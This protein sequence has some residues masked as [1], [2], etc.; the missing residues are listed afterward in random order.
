MAETVAPETAIALPLDL[1]NPE[2]L[3]QAEPSL[4]I[5]RLDAAE[6]PEAYGLDADSLGQVTSVNQLRDIQP[7]DWAYQA[8]QSLVERYGCL[9]GYPDGSFRGNRALTRFEFAAGLN[10]CLDRVQDLIAQGTSSN[11]TAEDFAVS[12]RLQEE[13]QAE[14]STLRSRVDAVEARTAQLEAN[15]FSPRT[16]L[17]GQVIAGLQGRTSNEADRFP[18]DGIKDFDDPGTNINLI[19]NV[20][21]SLL[22]QFSPRSLLL[23]GLQSGQGSTRPAASD[24][25]RLSYEGSPL[26]DATFRLSDLTY[27]HLVGDRLALIA[28]SRGVNGVSVFRGANRVESAGSGPLSFFAQRN[29]IINIGA[30]QAGAGFDWQATDR[31]SLQGVY[32][33][34]DASNPETGSLFGG[35]S[36][37]TTL[38]LQFTATPT[39]RL[40]LAFN[41]INAYTPTG[42]LGFGTGDS[43]VSFNTPL[44]TNAFG[45]TLAWRVTPKLTLGGWG[46]YTKSNRAGADG[47]VETTNWMAFLNL[48]NLFGAG[49]MGGLYVGQPP[50]IVSSDLPNGENI[51][52][53]LLQDPDE[54][55]GLPGTTT[56]IEA[57]YRYQVSDRLSLTPGVIV[58]L[59]PGNRPDSDTVTIG[60]V[61]A[62]LTF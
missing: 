60:G 30:G 39:D 20:Q 46:G 9:A 44:N 21:L 55:G 57:F 47:S 61:R 48:P 31:L 26:D 43:Q 18:V 62:T 52:A 13:F 6:R 42:Q 25:S 29:P 34:S 41:Y 3:S 37:N 56:H 7:T 33:S 32:S 22:T 27:R 59:N 1:S 2:V 58:L 11:V 12:Q 38:G 45:A 53:F 40:D 14:I 51:P 15:Q 16:R 49:N 19:S 54:T 24:D 36:N 10:A 8:V 28:G 17:S 4:D 35:T 50:K 23:I 5:D